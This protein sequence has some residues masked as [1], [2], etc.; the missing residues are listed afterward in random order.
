MLGDAPS[1]YRFTITISVP[2]VR[3][4]HAGY[5][6]ALAQ[7]G[8]EDV[9][10]VE[11]GGHQLKLEFR[12]AGHCASSVIADT[13]TAVRSAL[14]DALVLHVGP[15]LMPLSGIA[16]LVYLPLTCLEEFQR[17]LF[18][19]FP[20]PAERQHGEPLWRAAEVIGWIK[21]I[22]AIVVDAVVLET[23]LEAQAINDANVARR[24]G[25]V[26]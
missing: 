20:E 17:E 6:E 14:D 10:S 2:G 12:R 1:E 26:A 19:G 25:R 5:R 3:D 22:G 4:R 16:D 23:V 7:H 9:V 8:C 18:V 15:D 24:L 13:L 11:L 21:A